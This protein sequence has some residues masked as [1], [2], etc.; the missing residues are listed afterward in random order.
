MLMWVE[1]ILKTVNELEVNI[2]KSATLF[3]FN[4]TVIA[5]DC[6]EKSTGLNCKIQFTGSHQNV[7]LN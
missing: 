6:P 3:H 2:Q 1:N 7:T 5:K 4:K